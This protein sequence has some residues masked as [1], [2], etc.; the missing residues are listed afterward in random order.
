MKKKV[1]ISYAWED[2]EKKDQKV[3]RSKG[4]KI[5]PMVSSLFKKMEF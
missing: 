5:Y 3:K 2:A 1:F 4:K